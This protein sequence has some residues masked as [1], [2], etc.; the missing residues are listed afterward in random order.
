[1]EEMVMVMMAMVMETALRDG[2]DLTMVAAASFDGLLCVASPG[3]H[4]GLHNLCSV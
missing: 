2:L 1:M 3:W 4:G